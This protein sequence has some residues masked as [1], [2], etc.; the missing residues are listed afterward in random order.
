MAKTVAALVVAAGRGSRLADAHTSVPKQYRLLAGRP[1]LTHTLNVLGNHPRISH[2]VTVIH[3]DDI[4]LYDD[5][6]AAS[7]EPW[8]PKLLPAV[9]GSKTR[10]GSV[11]E[12]LRAL[13]AVPCDYVLIHDAARPF[14]THEVIDGLLAELDTGAEGA[15]AATQIVDTL[16]KQTAPG[17]PLET[18]DRE[19]LWA[20]QTPQAF[21]LARISRAHENAAQSGRRDFPDD[22]SLAEWDGMTVV[23]SAGDPANFKITTAADLRRA[24]KQASALTMPQ[25]VSSPPP[26]SDLPDIRMGTGYDVHAFED[27]NSVILG[28]VAIPHS[29]K[30]K[31]HSDADVVLHAITDATLGAIGDGDIGQHFPPSDSL[32]KGASSDRFQHDAMRRLTERGGR[33]AHIDVTVVCEEPKIGPHRDR[34]RASIADICRLPVSRVSVKATTSEK[35]GFTGRREGIAALACVTVRL[36]F[37]DDEGA[38]T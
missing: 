16:K 3:P 6:V 36:P 15:L 29:Q 1:V 34:I 32:W 33:I 21:P 8:Q 9:F 25:A 5:A 37:E 14:L 2:M 26:L 19:R 7:S 30:L 11:R 28:G 12:G 4:G 17:R 27:G 22:T 18:V 24:E 20:A 13:S 31:G 38:R 23:L 35:L 10:Q